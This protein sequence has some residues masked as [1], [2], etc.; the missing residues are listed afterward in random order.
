MA[1]KIHPLMF[2]VFFAAT[3][4]SYPA[5]A[6]DPVFGL[7][8]H[9]LYKGGVELHAGG[10]SEKSGNASEKEAELQFKYGLTSDWVIGVGVPYEFGDDEGSH[11]GSTSLSTK[12]RF[13]RQDRFAVQESMALMAKVIFDDAEDHGDVEQNG[14]DYLLGITYGYE[15]RKWY[16]W[17][18]V[19]QRINAETTPG[20]ARPDVW[21]VDLVGGIRFSPTEYHEPDWV[22]MLE[23]NGELIENVTQGVGS[24]KKQL[25]GNQWFLSPGL[26][27][28]HRNF[29]L[30]AGVQL[31]VI[32]DLSV[33]QEQDDYRAKIELEWHL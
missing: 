2:A 13:W 33:D 17:A 11:R 32:D 24:V 27:W 1:T 19:R 29:A 8:P 31:P 9:T 28:T 4:M 14:N 23:L 18:S 5:S 22:W 15:G 7:G 30:K 25:G 6:H 20:L 3:F 21:L 16:R 26:M 10:H 12:Y